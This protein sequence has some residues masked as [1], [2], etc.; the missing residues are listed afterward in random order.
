MRRDRGPHYCAV[1]AG[2]GLSAD[3][4]VLFGSDDYE[5][6]SKAT[7]WRSIGAAPVTSRCGHDA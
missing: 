1:S 5:T 2:G 4:N 7:A 6:F 3:L